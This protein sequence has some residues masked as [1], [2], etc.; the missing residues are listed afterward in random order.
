[1]STSPGSYLKCQRT[2]LRPS[3]PHIFVE[4]HAPG[5]PV[6]IH[7]NNADVLPGFELTVA[8]VFAVMDGPQS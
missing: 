5:Q 1:M 3:L 7:R 6:T 2:S 8:D 4:V